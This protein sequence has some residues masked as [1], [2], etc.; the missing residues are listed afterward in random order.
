MPDATPVR[1]RALPAG[2]GD[3]P[4]NL[5]VSLT[6]I[7]ALI[8]GTVTGVAGIGPAVVVHDGSILAVIANA[9]RLLTYEFRS[10]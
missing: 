5:Y 9:L 1:H 3:H 8:V 2:P 7:A 4:P 6:V 10:R